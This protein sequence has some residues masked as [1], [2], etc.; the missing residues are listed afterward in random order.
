MRRVNDWRRIRHPH[1]CVPVQLKLYGAWSSARQDVA[2]RNGRW[3]TAFAA[4]LFAVFWNQFIEISLRLPRLYDELAIVDEWVRRQVDLY[5]AADADERIRRRSESAIQIEHPANL[6]RAVDVDCTDG[7]VVATAALA[8][9]AIADQLEE[10]ALGV[11]CFRWDD[12]VKALQFCEVDEFKY[13][14]KN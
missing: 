10:R 14:T 1:I 8:I 2:N 9:F 5:T 12:Q 4:P 13:Y 11:A 6:L 3:G 7:I